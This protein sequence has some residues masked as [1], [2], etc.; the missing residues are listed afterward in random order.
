[1]TKKRLTQHTAED[2]LYPK[3]RGEGICRFCQSPLTTSFVDLGMSPLCE[4]YLTAQLLDHMEPY[5]PL[6]VLICGECFLV[7]LSES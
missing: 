6:H 7:Q 2:D 4:S 1:M 5:Y 3:V